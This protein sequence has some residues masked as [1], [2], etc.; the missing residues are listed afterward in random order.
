MA[1]AVV[2]AEAAPAEQAETVAEAA[3]EIAHV[4][5]ERDVQLAEISAGAATEIAATEAE[6]DEDVEWLRSEL[7]GLHT[8][9][10]TAEAA[11]SALESRLTEMENRQTSMQEQLTALALIHNPPAPETL[12]ETEM[13]AEAE[14]VAD[15][16]TSLADAAAGRAENP[17]AHA[18]RRRRYLR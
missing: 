9:C 11:S 17:E 15:E 6:H 12:S 3:V 1:P 10:A 16:A 13:T 14:A 5:A 2:V 4:E 8:R 7:A 18:Q